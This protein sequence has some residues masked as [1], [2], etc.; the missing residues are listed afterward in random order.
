[1]KKFLVSLLAIVLVV[2]TALFVACSDVKTITI[3]FDGNGGVTASGQT[4]VDISIKIIDGVQEE[5][6]YPVFTFAGHKF[7]GWSTDIASI[8]ADAKVAAQ[9]ETL[10]K[11]VYL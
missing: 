11:I 5:F 6:E 1:M 3:R 8:K 2:S 7:I 9:W 4:E 10:G